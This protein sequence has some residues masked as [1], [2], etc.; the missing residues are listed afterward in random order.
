MVDRQVDGQHVFSK[1]FS[2]Q[3][4]WRLFD[5]PLSHFSSSI[6]TLLPHSPPARPM[7][8]AVQLTV[9]VGD[10]GQLMS[11]PWPVLWLSTNCSTADIPVFRLSNFSVPIS[12]LFSFLQTFP[13]LFCSSGLFFRLFRSYSFLFSALQIFPLVCCPS[14]PFFF[15]FVN[16]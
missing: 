1:H 16:F 7:T 15:P 2:P 3:S 8:N 12:F 6:L 4:V 9:P 10:D 5:F 13:F 11:C 14:F